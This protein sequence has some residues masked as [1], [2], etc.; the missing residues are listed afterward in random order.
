MKVKVH[1]NSV[2]DFRR[3]LAFLFRVGGDEGVLAKEIDHARN[4]TGSGKNV[5][6]N[7][8]WKEGG[9]RATRASQATGNIGGSFFLGEKRE[10]GMKHDALAQLTKCGQAQLLIEFWL[11]RKDN[12]QEFAARSFEIEQQTKFIETLYRK[13][14]GL[15]KDENRQIHGGIA[16]E[17]P[18]MQ[19]RNEVAPGLGVARNAEIAQDKSQKPDR[20]EV[21]VEDVSSRTFAAVQPVE[22][23][24]QKTGLTG[25]S[26]A[27]KNENSLTSLN[28]RK[29]LHQSRFMSRSGI[30][31]TRVWRNVKGILT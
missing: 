15:I 24:V 28:A 8:I 1:R 30:V 4:A 12:L 13:G 31:K 21:G 10:A 9:V 20:F 14:M 16:L 17:K 2:D 6:Y 7:F 19:S 5:P 3:D 22:E 25:A 11:A 26:L 29:E 18:G 23:I 27:S